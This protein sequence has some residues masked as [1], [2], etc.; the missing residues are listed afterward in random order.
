MARTLQE[1]IN[2][3]ELRQVLNK[4][5]Y[6][7][8]HEDDD[9]FVLEDMNQRRSMVRGAVVKRFNTDTELL[10]YLED[11]KRTDTH[12]KSFKSAVN[13]MTPSEFEAFERIMFRTFN[14]INTVEDMDI[15]EVNTLQGEPLETNITMTSSELHTFFKH[16]LLM[17]IE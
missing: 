10:N 12:F 8:T 4:F 3:R 16:N 9:T 7:V 17:D 14:F 11:I 2:D 15:S 13:N 1:K 6:Q 5:N